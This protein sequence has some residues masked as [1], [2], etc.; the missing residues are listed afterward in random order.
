LPAPEPP[1]LPKDQSV[2]YGQRRYSSP[3]AL[4]DTYES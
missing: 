2:V 3:D 4:P 1:R